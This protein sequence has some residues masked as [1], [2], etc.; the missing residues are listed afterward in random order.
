VSLS[1]EQTVAKIDAL[2]KSN[3]VLK[4]QLREHQERGGG[5]LDH[6]QLSESASPPSGRGQK[7]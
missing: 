7:E 3:R 5:A 2:E 6:Q 4:E 1:L